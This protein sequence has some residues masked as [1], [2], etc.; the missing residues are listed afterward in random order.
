MEQV[1]IEPNVK[2]PK[3]RPLLVK[4]SQPNIRRRQVSVWEVLRKEGNN[5]LCA[6]H[7]K[8][9][10]YVLINKSWW[11]VLLAGCLYYLIINLLFGALYYADVSAIKCDSS[12][13]FSRNSNNFENSYSS[14]FYFSFQTMNTIG[15]GYLN[16]NPEKVYINVIVFLQSLVG[17]FTYGV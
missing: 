16:P 5:T 3:S 12:G 14:A 1:I 2:Y 11:E 9:P 17:I 8:G 4:H 6:S 7:Q 13:S 15:Y 10:F